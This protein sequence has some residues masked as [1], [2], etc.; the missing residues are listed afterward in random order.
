MAR[1]SMKRWKLTLAV[2]TV[3]RWRIYGPLRKKPYARS[4]QMAEYLV[5]TLA[6][7]LSAMG[8]PAGHERRGTMTA[9][10]KSA[11]IGLLGAALG[12][13]RADT[14][15]FAPLDA[16]NLA[17]SRIVD[18]NHLRDYHTVQTV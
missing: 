13:D 8:G 10:G 18:G 3:P 11:V 4:A 5:F 9:P 7:N 16:L 2:T 14:D 12:L 17:V 6:A 1:R 15:G